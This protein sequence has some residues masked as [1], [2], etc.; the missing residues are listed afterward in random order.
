MKKVQ[1]IWILTF[2]LLIISFTWAEIPRIMN[3]Q[4][5]LTDLDGVAVEGTCAIGFKI[6]DES[7]EGSPLWGETLSV[8]V[9]KGL[10]DV[11][12]GNTHPILL[13]FSVPYWM[14]ISVSTDGGTTWDIL[15]PREKLAT[16]SYAFRSIY[17]DTASFLKFM[18]PIAL[19]LPNPVVLC[20]GEQIAL[21]G[22]PHGG[23]GTY[24]VHLWTG[25]TSPLSATNLPNPTFLAETEGLYNLIYS[26]TDDR[27][28][29]GSDGITITVN[30]S[31]VVSFEPS[32][33]TVNE[34]ES[35]S[36][37]VISSGGSLSYQWQE[38]SG[39]GWL[40]ISLGGSEPAYSG[41]TTDSLTLSNVPWNY[42]GYDYRC[43]LSNPCDSSVSSSA[44]LTVISSWEGVCEET[45]IMDIISDSTGYIWMDRNLG[46]ARQ[47][48]DYNDHLAYGALFQWGRLSDD[49]ECIVWSD[50]ASGTPVN[51]AIVP[52]SSGDD[53]GHSDF[54]LGD[55]LHLDWRNPPND[56]LWQGVLGINNPCPPGYRLPT[57]TELENE[58]ESWD[59]DD[60][61]GAYSSPLKLVVA[62]Y[63][64]GNSGNLS[65]VGTAGLLWSSTTSG[66]ESYRLSFNEENAYLAL[67]YRT[68]G[69]CVR[70]IKD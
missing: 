70:C 65:G 30:D 29:S 5:K 52:T 15:E 25:D 34:G 37:G 64:L 16:L 23:S 57:Q 27:G 4:G 40:N 63:R 1:F 28:A 45:A 56:D 7:A 47:A 66:G 20:A 3:Y 61:E 69:F 58:L 35:V 26:V 38:N 14:E 46:A 53:P 36:F 48:L 39:E 68:Y 9:Y 24:S 31:P 18:P 10:F 62:G 19:I 55:S 17:C 8:N 33:Q 6:Y 67:S 12:L 32:N 54:I 50:S 59:T 60:R 43:K 42:N 44:N 13:D 22:H 11:Q 21:N 2:I 51:G 41:V 49:H